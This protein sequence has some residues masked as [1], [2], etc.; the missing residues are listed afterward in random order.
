MGLE[1]RARGANVFVG[2]TIHS[3]QSSFGSQN[4]ERFSEDPLLTGIIAAG[5]VKGLQSEQ[6]GATV[7]YFP[8]E[9]QNTRGFSGYGTVEEGLFRYLFVFWYQSELEGLTKYQG[10]RFTTLRNSD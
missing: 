10:E 5:F 6:V 9:K 8:S 2:P 1:L 7:E 4:I 3:Y